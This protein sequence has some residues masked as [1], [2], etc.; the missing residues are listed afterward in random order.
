[1][2]FVKNEQYIDWKKWKKFQ[3]GYPTCG[4]LFSLRLEIGQLLREKVS[5]LEVGYGSGELLG[6]LTSLGKDVTGV[7]RNQELVRIGRECGFNVFEGNPWDIS[8]ISDKRFDLIIALAV[9]EH[10]EFEELVRFF[11]WSRDH[12][13]ESGTLFLKFP[14]GSSPFGLGY[15]NGDFTHRSC[16]TKRKIEALCPMTKMTLV[17][18]SD[19]RLVSNRLC[20]FGIIGQVLLLA[21][22]LY[23]A[24]LKLLVRA[25]FLPVYPELSLATNSISLIRPQH[26]V[27]KDEA[28]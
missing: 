11:S 4:T 1:M 10:M 17:S 5:I 16:L 18:Y 8:E 21:L 2:F 20:S 12:L 3:F 23:S 7:E 26:L 28:A 13:S 22:H 27:E 6:F 19:E 25:I 24:T 15:Q 14:E 9:A